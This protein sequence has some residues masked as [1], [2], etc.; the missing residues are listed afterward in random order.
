[1]PN[2]V[3]LRGLIRE[4]GHWGEFLDI[5]KKT[6]PTSK[7]ICLDIPGA[8]VHYQTATPTSIPGI[9]DFMRA[10]LKTHTLDPQQP[11]VLLAISL[12]GMIAAQWMHSYPK[13]FTH[14]VLINTSY[15]NF[16]P[17]WKRLKP[18][19]LLKLVKVPTLKGIAKETRILEVVS[20]RPENYSKVAKLW[21]D[22][23]AKRPVSLANTVRQLWAAAHFKAIEQKPQLPILI[24]AAPEDKMVDVSCSRA[25]AK[26]WKV[27][28]VEHPTAGHDLV[29]D[30]P[31][32]VAQ[33]V[34]DWLSTSP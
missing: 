11:T 18:E 15:G 24:M 2:F 13:D 17:M 25:I 5:L 9:V 21:S 23:D 28:A 4:A 6:F 12:G 20:N 22:I 31:D 19:A 34:R 14:S 27:P 10:E 30:F 26:A 29:T 1:M 16:S 32:W 33:Q 7:I 8:G 3:L